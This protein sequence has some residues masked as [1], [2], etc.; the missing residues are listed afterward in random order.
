MTRTIKLASRQV[1]C[2][3][4]GCVHFNSLDVDLNDI[5]ELSKSLDVCGAN[6]RFAFPEVVCLLFKGHKALHLSSDGRRWG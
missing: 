3:N 6:L 2:I 4:D 1:V 5:F